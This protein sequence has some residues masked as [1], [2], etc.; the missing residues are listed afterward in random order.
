MA[1]ARALK[2]KPSLAKPPLTTTAHRRDPHTKTVGRRE[3]EELAIALGE[4][5]AWINTAQ[6]DM[7]FGV[8]IILNGIFLGIGVNQELTD[9]HSSE[10]LM[11]EG[12]GTTSHH[13]AHAT[14]FLV[15][16]VPHLASP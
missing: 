10:V 13:H 6:A 5:V 2:Q 12:M 4:E 7:A 16:S 14:T 1:T 9:G 15:A 3:K 11:I 8:A